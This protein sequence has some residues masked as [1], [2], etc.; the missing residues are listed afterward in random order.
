VDDKTEDEVIKKLKKDE[1]FKMLQLTKIPYKPYYSFGEKIAVLEETGFDT[2]S[3]SYSYSNV[4]A[5][6]GTN[7]LS[8]DKKIESVA[9]FR[10]HRVKYIKKI[11]KSNI[12]SVWYSLGFDIVGMPAVGK[13]QDGRLEVF[14]RS[15]YQGAIWHRRQGP[16]NSDIWEPWY[17]LGGDADDPSTITD[18]KG[19][20]YLFVRD[21]NCSNLLFKKQ[22]E[23]DSSDWQE[24][25]LSLDKRI[26]GTPS[27]ERDNDG[28]I[29]LFVL[30][31]SGE[32]NVKKQKEPNSTEW[33]DWYSLG[34]PP[35][36]ENGTSR[37][38]AGA[39]LPKVIS[40]ADGSLEL[41]VLGSEGALWHRRQKVPT[42]NNWYDW[43]SLKGKLESQPAVEKNKDGS[44]QVFVR[45]TDGTLWFRKQST[46]NSDQ[47]DN[48]HSLSAPL[49]P[50]NE[51]ENNHNIGIGKGIEFPYVVSTQDGTLEVFVRHGGEKTVWHSTHDSSN[52]SL[53]EQ[54][55]GTL[56]GGPVR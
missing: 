32:I 28:C 30:L 46:P 8:T 24:D 16:G 55:G 33:E 35:P 18:A 43:H 41:F 42:S 50:D 25:W 54:L 48:W 3:L 52:W 21:S 53:W 4:A 17:P 29:S 36:P 5:I 15:T 23:P 34:A 39:K 40:N 20:I 38:P 26:E 2:S 44:L 10:D 6:I 13:N 51:S 27:L 49:I 45:G 56:Q 31:P 11:N 22:M 7:A 19:C 14:V 9:D 1:V 12:A 37:L 47:W